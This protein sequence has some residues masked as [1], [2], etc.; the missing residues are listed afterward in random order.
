LKS[1]VKF[2]S[3]F[4]PLVRPT[5][6]HARGFV[7]IIYFSLFLSFLFLFGEKPHLGGK[8]AQRNESFLRDKKKKEEKKCSESATNTAEA[9]AERFYAPLSLLCRCSNTVVT[10]YTL[11]NIETISYWPLRKFS[12]FSTASLSASSLAIIVIF[13][14]QFRMCSAATAIHRCLRRRRPPQRRRNESSLK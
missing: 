13:I 12:H 8:R 11:F 6:T 14:V 1:L 10:F 7:L 2:F 5:L 9:G 4:P 3:S